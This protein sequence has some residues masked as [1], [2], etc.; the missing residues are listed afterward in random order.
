[1]KLHLVSSL[2][3]LI[4]MAGPPHSETASAPATEIK[5]AQD[6]AKESTWKVGS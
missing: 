1:M 5:S 3:N 2:P 4:G 6:T